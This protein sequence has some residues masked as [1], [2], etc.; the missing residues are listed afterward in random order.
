MQTM[1]CFEQYLVKPYHNYIVNSRVHGMPLVVYE[2]LH[3]LSCLV[4][5][6]LK[7]YKFFS[8]PLAI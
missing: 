8:Q 7:R 2:F 6:G 5:L 4:E 1:L 3:P